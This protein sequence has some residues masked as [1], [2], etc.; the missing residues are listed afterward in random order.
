MN[1]TNDIL[2]KNDTFFIRGLTKND[3]PLY[4]QIWLEENPASTLIKDF[5]EIFEKTYWPEINKSKDEVFMVFDTENNLIGKLELQH[6]DDEEFGIY[7]LKK[8]QNKGL[9]K[10]IIKEFFKWLRNERNIKELVI[11]IDPEN[12]RSQHIFTQLGAT[13][14]YQKAGLSETI[15]EFMVSEGKMTDD[16]LDAIGPYFYKITL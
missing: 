9:G 5:P 13:F 11:R 12:K 4:K 3:S 14:L 2:I 7:I 15:K 16:E 6:K 8:F 10:N 1:I